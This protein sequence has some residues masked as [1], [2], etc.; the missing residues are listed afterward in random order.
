[1]NNTVKRRTFLASLS[2]LGTAAAI[3]PGVSYGA[4]ICDLQEDSGAILKT[5]PYLQA[6]GEHQITV[7]WVTHVP[8]YSWVEYGESK[9]L[10]DKKAH[11]VNDGLIEAYNTIHSIALKNLQPGRSYFYRICSKKIESFAPYRLVYGDTFLSPAYSFRTVN[12]KAKDVSF[13]VF[14]D[15]HDRPDSFA[16]LMKYVESESK[17]FIF[18]NG[19]MFDFQIDENQLVSHLLA[20]F[21][22]LFSTQIPFF[23][24]R[25]N[26]ETR[27][28]FAR[29]LS[30]YFDGR[31]HQYYYSIQYGP[32]YAIVLDSGEDK[33]DKDP[34]YGGI[35]D[36]DSYRLKQAEW[37]K[38]E[39]QKKEYKRAKYK[40]VFSHIPPYYSGDWHGTMHCRKIWG[41][42]F[43][44][45]KID[46]L[47]S[48][49]THRY[50]IKQ[51]VEGEHNYPIVIGGGPRNG[52][53]TIMD[54]KADHRSFNLTMI[55]D[56]GVIV[57]TLTIKG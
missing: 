52:A 19:D 53:R 45:A 35:V 14:N 26:H 16:H 18:L 34:E 31:E 21:S 39:V 23:F 42:I 48:G 25:G 3:V 9:D 44:D 49:H 4:T 37:L 6:P 12:T 36:F 20:P 7:R 55:D 32:I 15:I 40:V 43:N 33:T 1:M 5:G 56:K 30:D 28:K 38:N 17:D 22:K 29:N 13:L 8:C 10:I 27:G 51:K 54:I 47:I 11:T 57:N 2:L 41:P 50:S 46:L 24:S